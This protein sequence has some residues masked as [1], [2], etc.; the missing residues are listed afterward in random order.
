MDPVTTSVR[1]SDAALPLV[2]LPG[3]MCDARLFQPQ[4]AAFSAERAVQVGCLSTASTIEAMADQVLQTAPTR[5]ALAG[6]SMGGIVAMEM[7][8]QAPGRIDRL[9]L[10]DTNPLAEPD[11]VA[12][13]RAEQIQRVME[14]QLVTVM[15]DELKPHYLADGPRRTEVLALCMAMATD[16]GVDVFHQQ[17]SALM[18]RPDQ[19]ATLST[20]SVPT[21]ILMGE[22]D[23][24]CPLDRHEL[25]HSLVTSSRFSVITGAGHMPTLEQPDSTNSELRQW[26]HQN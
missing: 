3:L 6:L 4:I 19:T 5:F 24:L 7:V 25:M 10:L 12:A 15:R 23:A 22:S 14:G 26:L 21:L 20:V 2:M 18:S 17:A 11:D 8:R 13:R 9:A 1:H 16:L